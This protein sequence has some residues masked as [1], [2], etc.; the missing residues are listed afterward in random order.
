MQ[1]VDS[2]APERD[3][4]R[5]PGWDI[6]DLGGETWEVVVREAPRGAR[7]RLSGAGIA[8]RPGERFERSPD[9]LPARLA[10]TDERLEAVERRVGELSQNEEKRLGALERARAEA[11]RSLDERGTALREELEEIYTHATQRVAQTQGKLGWRQRRHE[12]KLARLER[13]RKI[14]KVESR[15]WERSEE[16]LERIEREGLAVEE[17]VRAARADAEHG[18]AAAAGDAS[19]Q[20][21]ERMLGVLDNEDRLISLMDQ[22]GAAEERVRAADERAVVARER[23]LGSEGA[24]EL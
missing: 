7:E 6:V 11:E 10:R 13:D 8:S 22:I 14:R 12:L 18:F 21:Q 16:S 1:S 20:L 15:L 19:M 5:S 24:F 3:P 4:A 2:A 17:R 23:V 9:G